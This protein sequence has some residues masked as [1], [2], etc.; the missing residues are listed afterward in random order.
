MFHQKEVF[1]LI[2]TYNAGLN[3]NLMV[4]RRKYE[5]KTHVIYAQ[6]K[7]LNHYPVN[8]FVQKMSS[9]YDVG[10]IY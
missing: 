5:L 2:C 7:I 10:Y 6:L 4:S 1:S 3:S 8:I 9:A